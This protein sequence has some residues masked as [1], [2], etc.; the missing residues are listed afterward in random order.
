VDDCSRNRHGEPVVSLAETELDRN[1]APANR[2]PRHRHTL[3]PGAPILVAPC[4]RSSSTHFGAATGRP[5]LSSYTA[6]S[7]D[8]DGRGWR[9]RSDLAVADRHACRMR[10]GSR[11]A[12]RNETAPAGGT[13]SPLTGDRDIRDT[14]PGAGGASGTLGAGALCLGAASG[15]ARTPRV[16][17]CHP[18]PQRCRD[19]PGPGALDDRGLVGARWLRTGPRRGGGAR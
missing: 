4:P 16:I 3:R 7:G 11:A 9:C 6:G 1:Q 2:G 19:A 8:V 17:N 18:A 10:V 14:G 5:H 13:R 15:V 12:H